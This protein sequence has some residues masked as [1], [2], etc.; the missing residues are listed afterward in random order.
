MSTSEATSGRHV[1]G[2]ALTVL[3]PLVLF[4]LIAVL[5][6]LVAVAN[7]SLLPPLQTVF[8]ELV[9][10]PL[11]YLSNL[12]STLIAAVAGFVIGGIVAIVLAVAVVYVRVLRAAILPL[13]LLVNV[14]P[15]VAIAPALVVAF[16][17]NAVPHIVVAALSAFFPV[18]INAIS[19]LTAVDREALDVFRAM[20]GSP[21]EIFVHLRVPSSL[22]YVFAG[23]RLSVTAAMVGA[24]VSEFTGTVSGIGA[25]IITATQYLNLAQMWVGILFAAVATLLL[26]LLVGFVERL[27]VRW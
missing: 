12:S 18:L 22:R 3:A 15:I 21:F 24:V 14:T 4:V 9:S 16:G 27:V 2:I 1:G 11:F 5:W 17:F 7:S 8:A 10:R 25:V 13:A 6:E 19:G 23:A 26:L 20:S